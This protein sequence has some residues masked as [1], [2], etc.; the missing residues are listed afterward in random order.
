M[1]AH[2]TVHAQ[3]LVAAGVC[4]TDTAAGSAA[5]QRRLTL[6]TADRYPA[7]PNRPPTLLLETDMHTTTTIISQWRWFLA[8][9]FATLA[10]TQADQ[11]PPF[12]SW[13]TVALIA[14]GVY[15]V[16]T[17]LHRTRRSH[18]L[19]DTV[20]V[21]TAVVTYRPGIAALAV[22]AALWLWRRPQTVT[23]RR[24]HSHHDHRTGTDVPR[25]LPHLLASALA[26]V[27]ATTLLL[28]A[29]FATLPPSWFTTGTIST[30]VVLA[31]PILLAPNPTRQLPILACAAALSLVTISV[32]TYLLT[33]GWHPPTWLLAQ[34]AL[35]LAAAVVATGYFARKLP[36]GLS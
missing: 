35:L 26:A 3:V 2:L 29:L 1:P 12:G 19:A 34:A 28:H 22:L 16:A 13:A 15:L 24:P 11:L 33:G 17:V 30:A 5:R 27:A 4:R 14:T 10:A 31:T 8:A 21:T 7:D 25:H 9:A 36:D 20:W 18:A 32:A 23:T 6:P